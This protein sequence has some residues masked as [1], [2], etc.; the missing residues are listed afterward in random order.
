MF[1]RIP[2]KHPQLHNLIMLQHKAIRPIHS[3]IPRIL[4]H[5]QL[6]QQARDNGHVVGD[7]VKHRTVHAVVHRVEEDVEVDYFG[8]GRE[9]GFGDAG[10]ESCFVDFVVFL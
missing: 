1:P 3:H 9:G 6:R 5:V 4:A 2:I 7:V 10:D 8:G